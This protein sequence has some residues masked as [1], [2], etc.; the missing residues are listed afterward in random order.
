MHK[1]PASLV[2][3]TSIFVSSVAATTAH[4]SVIVNNANPAGCSLIEDELPQAFCNTFTL[5]KI[6]DEAL[7]LDGF[8]FIFSFDDV[9]VTYVAV[10]ND[11]AQTTEISG[12]PFTFYPVIL[13]TLER[14][15]SE[16]ET[17]GE[18]ASVCGIASDYSG[19]VCQTEDSSYLYAGDPISPPQNSALSQI[20]ESAGATS[21]RQQYTF[22]TNSHVNTGI[23][24][25]PG[26]VVTIQA[27]GTVQFGFFAG[28]GGPEGIFFNPDYNYFFNLLHGQL[29]GRVRRFGALEFDDW[30]PVGESAEIVVQTPGVLE[31]AVND[32]QPGNN[33]GSFQ[34]D[35]T[36]ESSQ[37]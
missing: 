22:N 8:R 3:A 26:D 37:N 35:V 28:S 33:A 23:S 13:K 31:F 9:Q 27:S 32:N 20:S 30:F 34:I 25:N 17:S 6:S 29:M 12:K 2:A 5:S 19:A 10:I 1:F 11:N 16:P 7:G 24:V 14:P 4:A 36:V 15:G 18:S 21:N